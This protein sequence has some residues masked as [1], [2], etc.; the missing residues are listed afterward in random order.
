[1]RLR[2]TCRSV[3]VGGVGRDGFSLVRGCGGMAVFLLGVV[4]SRFD[5]CAE[6]LADKNVIRWSYV[7]EA[8]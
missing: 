1:M 5:E 4:T 8:R 2:V 6:G 3:G 7:E